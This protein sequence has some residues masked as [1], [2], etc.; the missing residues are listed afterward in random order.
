MGALVLICGLPNAGKTTYS[1]RYDNVIHFDTVPARVG[2]TQYDACNRL[3]AETA[4]D[5]CVEGV[6]NQRKTRAGLLAA[7]RDKSPKV[8]VF[9]D[10]PP[11]VCAARETRNRPAGLIRAHNK[12]LQRPDLSEGWDEIITITEAHNG[13][14]STT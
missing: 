3:A 2:D 4:G 11:D 14:Q 12:T 8:C 13:L 6:Y 9:I 5:V 1:R 7:C 10:T